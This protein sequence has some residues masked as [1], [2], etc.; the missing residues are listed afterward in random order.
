[1]SKD[2]V[3]VLW[4]VGTVLCMAAV[5]QIRRWAYLRRNRWLLLFLIPPVA[6]LVYEGWFVLKVVTRDVARNWLG[7][8]GLGWGAL[9]W[10]L[11]ERGNEYKKDVKAAR[12]MLREPRRCRHCG[13]DLFSG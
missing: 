7:W 8:F 1:M 2:I 9:T 10:Y 11:W 3:G 12:G 5:G 13:A 6:V 4:F